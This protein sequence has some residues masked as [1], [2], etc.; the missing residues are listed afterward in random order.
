MRLA[1]LSIEGLAGAPSWSASLEEAQALPAPPLGMA[2]ADGLA[3]FAAGLDGDRATPILSRMGL[4]RGDEELYFD[5]PGFLEQANGLDPYEVEALLDLEA[6]RRVTITGTIELDPPLFGRLREESL[7]DPKMLAALG[8]DPTVTL[9]VGWLFSSDRAAASVGVLEVKVARTS[10]PTGR[11]ERPRWMNG[12]LRDVG[13]RL[14]GVGADA[15][16]D[17][18]G[19]QLLAAALSAD[20]EVRARYARLA[21]AM[22]AAPFHLGRLELVRRGDR[23][24]LAFGPALVRARQLGP[25]ALRALRVAHAA[26]VVAPD[27]LVVEDP[28]GSDW[29]DWLAARITGDHATLEQVLWMPGARS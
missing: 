6:G 13:R 11:S 21:D 10:F 15:S 9:K 4:A 8:E 29:S 19:E 24:Q 14:G 3:L 25:G 5:D 22:D 12:L 23:V 26:L 17:A 28:A 20:P 18:L 16:A 1:T 2:I 7:R 27:V